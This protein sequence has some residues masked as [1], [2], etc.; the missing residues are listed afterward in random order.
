MS[1]DIQLIPSDRYDH[2]W[3]FHKDGKPRG[4]VTRYSD[5]EFYCT[6]G[7]D[8]VPNLYETL[9]EAETALAEFVTFQEYRD[10]LI[11]IG[12]NVAEGDRRR[13]SR[14]VALRFVA[15]AAL[16]LSSACL[17]L[18]VLAGIVLGAVKLWGWVF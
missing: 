6:A 16:L 11:A 2:V 15:L 18:L 9:D 13:E 14:R 4:M 7:M 12:N 3:L 5:D 17:T 10:D 8:I 1:A